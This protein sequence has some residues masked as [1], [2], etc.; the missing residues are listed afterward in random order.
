MSTG[1]HPSARKT[2]DGLDQLVSEVRLP[3]ALLDSSGKIIGVSQEAATILGLSSRRT[4]AATL[5]SILSPRNPE[6]LSREIRKS[7]AEGAWTGDAV[8][9]RPDGRER[10]VRIHACRVPESLARSEEIFLLMEDVTEQEAV[11]SALMRRAEDLYRPDLGTEL[12][13]RVSKLMLSK[14][15]LDLPLNAMLKEVAEFVQA[16]GGVV[17]ICNRLTD[18]VTC[19]AAYR[20]C[21]ASFVNSVS[22][23]LNAESFAMEAIRTRETRVTRDISKEPKVIRSIVDTCKLKAAVCVPMVVGGEPLGAVF[24]AH[25]TESKTFTQEEIALVEVVA[26]HAAVAVYSRLLESDMRVYKAY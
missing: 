8:L 21:P 19:R 13:S 9:A 7:A 5:D 24:L 23:P 3:M 20:D 14:S 17:L 25:T 2:K 12:I 15:D 1:P 16:D 22:V 26:N 18:E 4:K 11:S 6:W 10:R